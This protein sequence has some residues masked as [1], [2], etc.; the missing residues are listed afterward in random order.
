MRNTLEAIDENIFAYFL[1]SLA[2]RTR[3]N[4][5]NDDTSHPVS[6]QFQGPSTGAMTSSLSCQ[7]AGNIFQYIPIKIKQA[8]TTHV[9]QDYLAAGLSAAPVEFVALNWISV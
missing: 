2:H 8:H 6:V 9:P 3:S 5:S 7:S 1:K 4:D